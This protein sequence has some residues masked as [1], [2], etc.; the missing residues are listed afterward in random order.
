MKRRVVFLLFFLFS[1]IGNA[2]QS[3]QYSQYT[4]NN[5]GYNPAFLGTIPCTDFRAGTIIQWLGFR[6]A[7]RSSFASLQYTIPKKF[8]KNSAKHGVGLYVEQDDVHLTTRT[9]VKLAYAYHTKISSKYT[10]GLGI[11]AGIQQ[12]STDDVFG[13]T[14]NN[15][16]VLAAA[17][18]SVLRYPDIMPGVLLYSNKIY[19]SLSINQLY[20]KS[21]NLGEKEAQVNQYYFGFGHK[22]AFGNWTVFKSF[23]LKQN[24]MG[25]PAL[26]L[27]MA[28]VYKQNTTFGL[29]YRVG[30]SVIAQ[31]KFKLGSLNVG[32]AFDFPLNKIYGN[33]GHEIMIGFNKCSGAGAGEGGGIKP[34]VCPA[35]N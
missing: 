16:P 13:G 25:P 24:I 5:F 2:Q 30:E 23:L 7:P 18:G 9:F 11:F 32:Y 19:W 26:D 8:Y 14:T 1:V 33:Y 10:M 35:Y 17:A 29:C 15:D 27:N 34:H 22:S 6:G 4:F 21:I 20:F 28:W 12:Y 3:A 31:L